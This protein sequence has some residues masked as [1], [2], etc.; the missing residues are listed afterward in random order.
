MAQKGPGRAHREGISI[1]ELN[2]MFPDEASAVAWFEKIRWPDGE[3][4]CAKCG[5][6][7]TREIPNAKPMPYWCGDCKSYFSVRTGTMMESSR[8]PIRKWVF[9]TY[10]YVT[11]L[12]GVS[13]VKLRRDIKVT[14][15][16]AW[17]ML[18]RLREA[19]DQSGLERF[20][21]PTEADETYIGGKRKNMPKSKRKALRGRGAVGKSAVVGVKDRASNKVVARHVPAT[22]AATVSGFVAEQTE[23]GA[24]VYTDEST[25]YNPLKSAYRHE[26]VNHSASEYV[27][28]DASVNGIEAFWSMFK[29]GFHGTYHKM[30]PKH[31]DRYV[32][33]FAARHNIRDADTIDQMTAAFT[34]MVGKYLAYAD[35]IADNGLP[36]GARSA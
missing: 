11:N 21:G 32:A 1:M 10:L 19:W 36:S 8:L 23:L 35:L 18:H 7:N 3:R 25:V 2:E 12:K 29:R 20:V 22:D 34:Q 15:K 33:E 28:G 27:R 24:T 9:A 30:S 13:S 5:S 14:Q 31:L 6:V 17:F 26:T 16:T 4:H